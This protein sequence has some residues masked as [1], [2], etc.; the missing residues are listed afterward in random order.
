MDFIVALPESDGYDKIWVIVDRLTKMARFIPLKSGD[1]SPVSEL[2]KAFGKGDL[3]I[4]WSPFRNPI[5]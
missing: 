4:A 5:G 1:P 3:A 2:A